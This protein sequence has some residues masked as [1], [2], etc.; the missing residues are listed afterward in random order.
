MEESTKTEVAAAKLMIEIFQICANKPAAVVS[1]ALFSVLAATMH[2][3]GKELDV[4]V[5]AQEEKAGAKDGG[6]KPSNIGTIQ[7]NR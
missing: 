4:I 3:M 5:S 7:D 6:F 2:R 1:T